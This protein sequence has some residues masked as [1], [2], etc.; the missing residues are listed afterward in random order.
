MDV[1]HG[2]RIV[3]VT[4]DPSETGP[5]VADLR[6]LGHRVRL[7]GSIESA[8]ELLAAKKAD[9]VLC[10]A[11]LIEHRGPPPSSQDTDLRATVVGAAEDLGDLLNNLTESVDELHQLVSATPFVRRAEELIR[12]RQRIIRIREFIRDLAA[13]IPNGGATQPE[14]TDVDLQDI[15]ER[16][17]ITVYG[18]AYG[19]DQRL[20]LNIDEAT[21]RVRADPAKLRRVLAVLLCRAVQEAPVSG[22][23]TVEAKREGSDC[24]ITV[25]D[26]GEGVS[27]E[28]I[29]R[30]F[31]PADGTDET[32]EAEARLQFSLVRKLVEQ[33]GGRVWVDSRRG[34]GTSVIVSLPQSGR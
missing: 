8:R 11:D 20:V 31:Q 28:Q 4:T 25:T 6:A 26:S 10:D 34:R 2:K 17:A 33:H 15:V 24:L 7:A 9:L 32:P 22:A 3:L 29:R 13:E 12:G 14:M 16:A 5:V 1:G 27:P 18:D 19:K 21:S 30:L 23:V